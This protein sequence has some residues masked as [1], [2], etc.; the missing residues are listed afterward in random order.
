MTGRPAEQAPGTDPAYDGRRYVLWVIPDRGGGWSIRDSAYTWEAAEHSRE[1]LYSE[2]GDVSVR[3]LMRGED[4]WDG[5]LDV[6]RR[7]KC[8]TP[9]CDAPADAR[10]L[11]HRHGCMRYMDGKTDHP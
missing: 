7:D 5:H 6:A 10:W 4:P 9:G 8:P 11:E 1:R 2:L 3:V